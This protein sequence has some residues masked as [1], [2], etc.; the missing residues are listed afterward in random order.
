MSPS[1]PFLLWSSAPSRSRASCAV[2][3]PRRRLH[4]VKL[5]R[6]S[7]APGRRHPEPFFLQPRFVERQTPTPHACTSELTICVGAYLPLS[8]GTPRRCRLSVR[9]TLT[10]D[11]STVGHRPVRCHASCTV[12]SLSRGASLH[13]ICVFKHIHSIAE[14]TPKWP[15]KLWPSRLMPSPLTCAESREVQAIHPFLLA[16]LPTACFSG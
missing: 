11:I 16:F 13:E 4:P 8:D 15:R 14:V 3:S 10:C 9:V 7:P 6:Q 12:V 2:P 5:I 1:S